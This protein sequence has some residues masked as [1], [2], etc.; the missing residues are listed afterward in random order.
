MKALSIFANCEAVEPYGLKTGSDA[1]GL[2]HIYE[3]HEVDFVNKGISRDEVTKFVMN[4]LERGNIVDT[5]GSANV[6]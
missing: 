3:R 5:I 1:A 4:V 2:R 6:Y